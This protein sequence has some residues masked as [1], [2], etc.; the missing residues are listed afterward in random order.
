MRDP[1]P[2]FTAWKQAAAATDA[3]VHALWER[4]GEIESEAFRDAMRAV[5]NAQAA[6]AVLLDEAMEELRAVAAINRHRRG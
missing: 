6:A 3:M 1:L 5:G 2:K 4:R